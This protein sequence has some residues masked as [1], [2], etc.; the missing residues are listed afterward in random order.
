MPR[1]IRRNPATNP[2][3]G[4][5][6]LRPLLLALFAALPSC[7]VGVS[8]PRAHVDRSADD[9]TFSMAVFH[10]I[11]ILRRSFFWDGEGEVEDSGVLLQAYKHL[12][13]D[14]A[15]G[16]GAN[17]ASWW[18]PG[19]N[20]HSAE[21]EG[22]VR[23]YP[24]A[25]WPVFFDGSAGYQ[26]ADDQI[27]PGGTVWNFTFSFG[28][29]FELPIAEST[30]FQFGSYYHHISNALGRENDRNPSQNEVRIWAGI[31]FVF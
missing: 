20:V 26:L 7:A 15:I 2:G 9:A 11:P 28:P 1:A 19:R 22:R 6:G 29:G 3:V 30:R 23:L 4:P 31:S 18:A 14:F 5:S 10:G 16:V 12:T 8:Q 25:G 17:F 27:P 13:D 21:L 24:V